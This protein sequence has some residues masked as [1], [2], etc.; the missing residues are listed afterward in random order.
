MCLFELCDILHFVCV[1]YMLYFVF[2]EIGRE[3]Q[4][5]VWDQ[6]VSTETEPEGPTRAVRPEGPH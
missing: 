6:R 3:G 4:T 1:I 5:P 2:I